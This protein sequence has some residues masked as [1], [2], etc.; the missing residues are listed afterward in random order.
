M[1]AFQPFSRP[2]CKALV[3]A[4]TFERGGGMLTS[5]G[6]AKIAT[7]TRLGQRGLMERVERAPGQ[8]WAAKPTDDG[9]V[10]AAAL[11]R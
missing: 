4:L 8:R 1:P 9:R 6:G 11:M 3:L 2:Q 5:A 7:V 10:V